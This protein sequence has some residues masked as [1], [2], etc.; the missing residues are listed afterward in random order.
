MNKLDLQTEKYIIN[1][2]ISMPKLFDSLGIDY[3]INANMFCPF[4]H[5]EN[6]PSAHLYSDDN[7]YRLW[8]FSE[9]R[10]YGAWN[11]YKT[12]LPKINTNLLAQE[13]LNQMSLEQQKQLLN[14]IGI[15]NELNEIPYKQ[16]LLDFKA[17][18]ITINDLII[19]ISDSYID[20]A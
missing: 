19:K 7:G 9:Y 5:N 17:N 15:E 2:Y 1:R 10:M 16:A 6:T 12:Y 20:E 18:K 8:C 14:D 11:I 3:R 13:I 4:H